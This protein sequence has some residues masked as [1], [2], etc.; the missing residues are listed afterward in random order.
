VRTKA[1]ALPVLTGLV[2]L[3]ID[4]LGNKQRP[5]PEKPLSKD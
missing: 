2:A 5:E 3:F 1:S 4:F